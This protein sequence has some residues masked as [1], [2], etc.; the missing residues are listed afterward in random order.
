[1][2]GEEHIL[3]NFPIDT[4]PKKKTHSAVMRAEKPLGTI[5]EKNFRPTDQL[6]RLNMF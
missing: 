4:S 1:M 2:K 3:V 5:Y 6:P